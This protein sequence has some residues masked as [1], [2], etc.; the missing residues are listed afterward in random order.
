MTRIVTSNRAHVL[1]HSL[2]ATQFLPRPN[3]ENTTTAVTRAA[4]FN[5][6]ILA[7]TENT[8]FSPI[9]RWTFVPNDYRPNID[10]PP[11]W[12]RCRRWRILD[13]CLGGR[14][15]RQPCGC[16]SGQGCWPPCRKPAWQV[17][18]QASWQASW[19][20][21]WISSWSFPCHEGWQVRGRYT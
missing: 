4:D 13:W 12:W 18:W 6:T 2:R 7:L 3:T 19:E 17:S 5:V 21:R 9:W 10:W 14:G 15:N 20:V 1:H 16:C 8:A 11:G